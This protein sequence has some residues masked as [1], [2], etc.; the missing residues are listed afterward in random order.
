MI[1]HVVINDKVL[2]LTPES[3]QKLLSTYNSF[4]LSLSTFPASILELGL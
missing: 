2:Q 4:H 3:I 1:Y